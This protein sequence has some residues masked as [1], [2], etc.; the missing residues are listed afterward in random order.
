VPT[1]PRRHGSPRGYVKPASELARNGDLV[2]VAPHLPAEQIEAL[3]RR[4]HVEVGPLRVRASVSQH[5]AAACEALLA[6]PP[7]ELP[8]DPSGPVR[9]WWLPLSLVERVDAAF[10]PASRER[11]IAAAVERY[12]RRAG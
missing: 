11:A 12:L 6:E 5:I 10:G 7:R 3:R 9:Q 1:K 2:R 8:G 4:S